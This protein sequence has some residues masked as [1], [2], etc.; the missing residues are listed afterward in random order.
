M[1]KEAQ[2]I[3]DH[4]NKWQGQT[5]TCHL[6]EWH[7]PDDAILTKKH[8][9][10]MALWSMVWPSLMLFGGALLVGLVMLTQYLANLCNQIIPEEEE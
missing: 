8:N 4:F 7:Y 10:H 1:M 5:V 6:S 2:A 3:K 9:L